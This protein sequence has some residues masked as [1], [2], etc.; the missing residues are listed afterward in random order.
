MMSPSTMAKP[1]S[2]NNPGPPA[3]TTQDHSLR[4]SPE[5]LTAAATMEQA[6]APPRALRN[7]S[8]SIAFG[9]LAQT[10]S[11]PKFPI[12]F[13]GGGAF[14]ATPASAHAVPFKA[15]SWEPTL[16]KAIKAIIS[17]K[18]NHVRSFDTETSGKF[19]QHP[20]RL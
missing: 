12:G 2:P 9:T 7:R 14:G 17:I 4:A 13:E 8:K 10:H 18:A 15:R 16:E 1:D 19:R 11:H 3:A 6:G 5:P 20:R